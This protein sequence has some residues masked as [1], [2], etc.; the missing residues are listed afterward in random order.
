MPLNP[1][2]DF[3]PSKRDGAAVIVILVIKKTQWRVL[4]GYLSA[5][6][7]RNITLLRRACTSKNL[8]P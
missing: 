5:C 4:Y 8:T 6:C 3:E 2:D 1:Q 7:I